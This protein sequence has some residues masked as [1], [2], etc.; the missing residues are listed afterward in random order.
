L[1]A[2][3]TIENT[4]PIS[5]SCTLI[6]GITEN[7]LESS[8]IKIY[9]NP[10]KDHIYIQSKVIIDTMKVELINELGQILKTSEILKGS[11]LNKI[12]TDALD[13]GLYFLKI[14]SNSDSKTYKVIVNN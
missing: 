14:S 6:L 2:G 12:E 9:P 5:D 11:T 7:T 4:N 8:D 10:A 3:S 13:N 1:V